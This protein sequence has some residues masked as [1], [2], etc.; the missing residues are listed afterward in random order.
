M[1]D[2]PTWQAIVAK[3]KEQCRSLI[4]AAWQ[5]PG[6]ILESLTFPLDT[7]PNKVLELDI[8]RKSGI[9]TDV[10]LDITEKYSVA[11]LLAKLASGEFTSL[12]VTTAFCKRAAIAQQLVRAFP[13]MDICRLWPR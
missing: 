7:N 8:P 1:G 10:E 2:N 9:L 12:E 4:P 13:C 3:K 11:E 5:L 6:S